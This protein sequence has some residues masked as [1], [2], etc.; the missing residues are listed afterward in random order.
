[1]RLSAVH[2]IKKKR[3]CDWMREGLDS[4]AIATADLL[5]IS[6]LKHIVRNL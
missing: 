5:T 4:V 3:F 2:S 6:Q 1:M